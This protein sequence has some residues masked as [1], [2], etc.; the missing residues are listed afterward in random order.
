MRSCASQQNYAPKKPLKI[1]QLT[2]VQHSFSPHGIGRFGWVVAVRRRY[3][4]STAEPF[5]Y[6]DGVVQIIV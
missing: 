3:G 4:R 6:Y 5:R 2:F 1:K